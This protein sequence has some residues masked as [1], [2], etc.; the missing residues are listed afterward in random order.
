MKAMS[1]DE[2]Y[3]SFFDWSLSTQKSYSYR[4]SD[5]GDPEEVYE[6]VAEFAFY[7][8][9]FATRFVEKALASG[10]KFTPDHVLEMTLL[11][12]KPVLSRMAEQ[13][14]TAFTKEQ[15]EEVYMLID[16]ASFERISKKQNIDIFEDDEPE[17]AYEPEEENEFIEPLP[18]RPGFFA[19]LFAV[20]AGVSMAGGPKQKKHNG[21]CNGDCAN[22]SPHYGYRYGRWY[23]GHDHVHGCQFGGN[24]GS[25]SMD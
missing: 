6:V 23:Y 4:L 10:V 9:K 5:F 12:E 1:W 8:Q 21:R 25:G 14:S 7:D 16:D 11:I 3:A 18:K 19:T 22:C 15:L 24:R 2:Y 17:E 20:I 13:T